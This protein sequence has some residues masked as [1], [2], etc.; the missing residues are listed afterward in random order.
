[1]V[2]A[3]II[4]PDWKLSEVEEI[5]PNA[6]EELARISPTFG[7]LRTAHDGHV[8]KRMVTVEQAAQIAGLE[9]QDVVARLNKAAGIDPPTTMR[10][11]TQNG[12]PA[13]QQE[14]EP[15]WLDHANICEQLDVRPYQK[16]GEEPFTAIMTRAAG[17]PVGK[18]L[19]L[20][21]TFEP[22]P[23]YDVLGKKGFQHWAVQYA[24]DDWEIFFYKAG[25]HP[26]ES[27][28]KLSTSGDQS[29]TE[30]AGAWTAPTATIS[31][32]VS[33]LIPP[34]PMIKILEALED[35]EPGSSLLVN[36][37][38]RP[39]HLYPRLDEL[40][41]SH[42]TQEVGPGHVQ[43]LIQKSAESSGMDS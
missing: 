25:T 42:E 7:E 10:A 43:V 36:H 15:E 19:S 27:G 1:M 40:D 35:L 8:R 17:V 24:P 34:E 41:Y 6:I 11:G 29:D 4:R 18:I 9:I 2:Q 38:R 33:E 22:V 16:H 14:P 3:E 12:A 32:D 31:I 39:M 23:L 20:R 37:V 21:N 26:E 30:H 28:V 13:A 5:Y